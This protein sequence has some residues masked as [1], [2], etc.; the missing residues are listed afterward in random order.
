M[1][2]H[3]DSIRYIFYHQNI[4]YK[5]FGICF[6]ITVVKEALSENNTLFSR[7]RSLLCATLLHQQFLR[8]L[9]FYFH[10]SL[11]FC[12][13]Y[14]YML[15]KLHNLWQDIYV[16]PKTDGLILTYTFHIVQKKCEGKTLLQTGLLPF[17]GEQKIKNE[18]IS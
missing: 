16:R 8:C 6:N 12:V 4:D 10:I 5:C 7:F 3:S 9:S 1:N 14:H 11:L 13:D 15:P 2:Q 17:F 18:S